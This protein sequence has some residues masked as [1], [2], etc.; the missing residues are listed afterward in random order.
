MSKRKVLA[1]WNE[2]N[3]TEEP[4]NKVEIISCKT[5]GLEFPQSIISHVRICLYHIINILINF[6]ILNYYSRIEFVIIL[7]QTRIVNYI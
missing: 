1:I 5:C 3:V 7:Q 2:V 6:V 4:N